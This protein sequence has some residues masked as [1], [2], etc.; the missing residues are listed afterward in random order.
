MTNRNAVKKVLSCLLAFSILLSWMPMPALAVED[1]SCAH[2]TH[3]ESCGY[4]EAAAGHPCEHVCT[5]ACRKQVTNCIHIHGTGTCT[6]QDAV[7]GVDCTC[8]GLVHTAQCAVAAGGDC[9]C[10]M[11]AGHTQECGYREAVPASGTCDHSACTEESGCVTVE[12]ACIHTTHDEACKFAEAKGAPCKLAP[13]A[14]CAEEKAAAEKAAAEKAAAK[15]VDFMEYLEDPML[16]AFQSSADIDLH[17]YLVNAYGVPSDIPF[18]CSPAT[19]PYGVYAD[20]EVIPVTVTAGNG[21]AGGCTVEAEVRYLAKLGVLSRVFPVTIKIQDANGNTVVTKSLSASRDF[22][23]YEGISEKVSATLQANTQYTLTVSY[24]PSPLEGY[25]SK[26]TAI[27]SV[28]AT[29]PFS[30][31]DANSLSRSKSLSMGSVS[32]TNVTGTSG[33]ASCTI[34]SKDGYGV[35]TVRIVLQGSG[36]DPRYIDL[37]LTFQGSGKEENHTSTVPGGSN[38]LMKAST[39]FGSDKYTFFWTKNGTPIDG[40]TGNIYTAGT[41]VAND[42]YVATIRRKADSGTGCTG[43]ESWTHTFTVSGETLQDPVAV[44]VVYNGQPQK[45]FRDGVAPSGYGIYYYPPSYWV[46]FGHTYDD[47]WTTLGDDYV[48]AGTYNVHYYV[49][50][51]GTYSFDAVRSGTLT[52]RILKAD[53]VLTK[54][55]QPVTGLV[56]N[57]EERALITGGEATNGSVQYRL[58]GG[59]WSGS[60]PTARAAGKY[61]VEYRIV[62]AN[63]NYS[64]L[65]S[66]SYKLEVEIKKASVV[67]DQLP[68]AQDDLV[69]TGS[70][71]DLLSVAPEELA[72]A[73]TAAA[74][75]VPQDSDYKT[76]VP[77]ATDANVY[78]VW[79][80]MA[81]DRESYDLG[82][83]CIQVWIQPADISSAVVTLS[84]DKMVYTGSELTPTVAVQLAP[85]GAL[86][87]GTDFEAEFKNNT[88]VG[89]ATVILTGMGN[90][91][92][93]AEK[94]FRIEFLETDADAAISGTLGNGDWYVGDVTLTAPEGFLISKE[95]SG[96]YAD[97]V[98]YTADQSG[99]ITYYLKNADT[100]E[101]A[102]KTRTLKLDKTVPTGTIALENRPV[103]QTLVSNITFGMF[104]N[105]EQTVTVTGADNLSGVAKTEYLESATALDQ[106]ALEQASWKEY[107]EAISVTL[108]DA[109]QFIYY[110]KITDAAGNV[111]FLSTD[112]AVY[113]TEKPVITVSG[114]TEDN[115]YYTTQ[116]ITV[117]D[118]NLQDVTVNDQPAEGSSFSVAGDVEATYTVTAGDKAENT[119]TVVITMKP[120]ATLDD[121]IEDLTEDTATSAD[122]DKIQSV[123]DRVAALLEDEE[124]PQAEQDKLEQIQ[125]S[126]QAMKDAVEQAQAAIDNSTTQKVKDK[127]ENNV[128]LV[129]KADLEA[130]KALLEDALLEENKGNYTSEE[131]AGIQQEIDR[132]E[133]AIDAITQTEDVIAHIT[134]LPESVE[135]DLDE[136]TELSIRD[137]MASYDQ[138]SD[139]QKSLIGEDETNKLMQLYDTLD[140]YDIISSSSSRWAIGSYRPLI[141]TANGPD[142][143]FEEL[144]V[145]GKVVKSSKYTH[146]DGSTIITLPYN[147]L[148]TLSV[149]THSIQVVYTD[150]ETDGRDY[151]RVYLPSGTPTT[152]DTTDLLFAG[153]AAMASLL[154]MFMMV[155]FVPRKKGKYQ[156]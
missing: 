97:A 52:C 143:K 30:E 15:T 128:A 31:L 5:D 137:A 92:G 70:A 19:I 108:E 127:T 68:K 122:L 110:A 58:S 56:F 23:Y 4:V 27:T 20:G 33:T 86:A 25:G 119:T 63:G 9:D 55:P 93:K 34:N 149:G 145:D 11:E 59:E 71:Q 66:S 87:Y 7:P 51:D 13:C 103:W 53:P 126:A 106:A 37:T 16:I 36:E 114:Q 138:L 82:T 132:L 89:E 21:Y 99:E 123:L 111:S 84:A 6:Y 62:G 135:P 136:Q 125:S 91:A 69:Y 101:V 102:K 72:Y 29:G 35:F 40:A 12:A 1:G 100:G 113:D 129:D 94:T 14:A 44:D 142:R 146:E 147:Y 150:G 156:K 155:L 88:N 144:R 28:A 98:T 50:A 130:A 57:G 152:D 8:G 41:A 73:V 38:I 141:F 120:I 80:A 116:R 47:F 67:L 22:N 112:G 64:T 115:V 131:Q 18:T 109:K 45:L 148:Q 54:A 78:Y 24:E 32:G 151:F 140:N 104:F 81:Q 83:S 85:F 139:H 118:A 42:V 60:I 3:D 61:T 95:L 133:K 79:F 153:G 17:D 76:G 65:E 117:T 2:H 74:S 96:T 105:Y 77:Q 134:Q 107:Q 48:N 49:A 75:A 46:P 43:S 39:I 121:S 10:A 124:L 90:F 26:T 154:C